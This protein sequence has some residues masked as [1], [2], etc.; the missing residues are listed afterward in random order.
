MENRAG[1]GGESAST[2]SVALAA[3]GGVGVSQVEGVLMRPFPWSRYRNLNVRR[4]Q[5]IGLWEASAMVDH[6]HGTVEVRMFAP[7]KRWAIHLVGQEAH[8]LY[9]QHEALWEASR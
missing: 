6:A 8:R 9:R 5:Q 7:R 3:R 1:G 2:A 4:D